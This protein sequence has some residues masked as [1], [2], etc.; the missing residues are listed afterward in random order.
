MKCEAKKIVAAAAALSITMSLNVGC[1]GAGGAVVQ[2]QA[3]AEVSVNSAAG[4]VDWENGYVYAVGHGRVPNLNEQGV[5]DLARQAAIMDAYRHLVGAVQGVQV[6]ADSLMEML[7]LKQDTVRN[8]IAGV[9]KGAKIIDEGT[10]PNGSAYVKMVAPMYGVNSVASAALPAIIP[11]T[12]VAL[13]EVKTPVISQVEV[14][15]V[16]T[17]SYT[18]VVVDAS[19]LGLKPAMSPVIYDTNGRAVYGASNIDPDYAVANGMVGYAKSV[20]ETK[21]SKRTGS[22]A[23]VVKAVAVKGGASEIN[24]VNVVVSPEDAD[25]ILISNQSS[26]YLQKCAVT[27]VR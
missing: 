15:Q 8:K 27:F 20:A 13:P 19:G 1:V 17:A 24:K 5:E 14:T 12:P 11:S 26:S 4:G 25:R 18:G 6:D 7:M 9:V 22:N 10:L 21:N 23:L 3:A 2:A 16:T